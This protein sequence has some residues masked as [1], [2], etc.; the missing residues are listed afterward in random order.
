MD[1]GDPPPPSHTDIHGQP[2]RNTQSQTHT[3]LPT[4]NIKNKYKT[5]KT[6][7]VKHRTE[8]Q[9]LKR[10]IKSETTFIK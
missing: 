6:L 10:N 9:F 5:Y 7:N 2:Y 3:H 4:H 1:D 8:A